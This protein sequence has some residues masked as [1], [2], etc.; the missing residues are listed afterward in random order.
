VE[1]RP[2]PAVLGLDA[3]VGQ[4]DDQPSAD[5]LVAGGGCVAHMD[6]SEEHRT[7][8]SFDQLRMAVVTLAVV[9]LQS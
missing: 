4:L 1:T 2:Y 5:Q 8:G 3:D 7:P 9:G 6:M